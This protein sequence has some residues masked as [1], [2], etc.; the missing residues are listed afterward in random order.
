MGFFKATKEGDHH[1]FNKKQPKIARIAEEKTLCLSF[2]S[3]EL[4]LSRIQG[5]GSWDPTL[6]TKDAFGTFPTI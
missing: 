5:E 4:L 2:V 3:V 1:P 6:E